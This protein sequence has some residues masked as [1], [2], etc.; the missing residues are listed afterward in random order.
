[1]AA[2]KNRQYTL[3]I[4]LNAL[5]HLGINLYSNIP[6]VISETVANSWDADAKVVSI[7][8]DK[9]KR[10]VTI[11]DDG[12][13]M[14]EDELNNRYL[15]VG[16]SKRDVEGTSTPIHGRHVMG[17]KGIGK[18][19]L[20]SIARTIEVHTVR[21]DNAGHILQR[22]ALRMNSD[23]IKKM[24]NKQAQGKQASYK[25]KALSQTLANMSRGTR[26]IISDLKSEGALQVEWIRK[27]LARRFSII[28]EEFDFQVKLDEKPIT[29]E[30]RD[31]FRSLQYIW[32]IGAD[33]GRFADAAINAKKKDYLDG[34]VDGALNYSV[35]G[36]IGTFDEQRNIDDKENNSIVV[37]AWGKLVQEDILQ[38]VDEAGLFMKYLIGEIRADFVDLDAEEDIATSDRQRLQK[39]E[40]RYK[41]LL[42]YVETIVKKTIKLKWAEWRK[43]NAKERALKNDVVREWY[44]Q[45]PVDNKKYA[46]EVFE[47]IETLEVP[48]ESLRKEL[49]KQSIL[50]FEAFAHRKNLSELQKIRTGEEFQRL[51]SIFNS[52]DNLEEA[53]FYTIAKSR[54]EALAKLEN[55]TAKTKERTIQELLFDHLWLLDT[56]WERPT[57]DQKMEAL[58]GKEWAKIDAKLTSDEKKGR[59]DIF[60]KTVAGKHIIIELKAYGVKPKISKL[61]DQVQK[62]DGA[63]RKIAKLCDPL[64][65]PLV[66]TICI[67]GHPPQ[68]SD[69][70]K[71]NRD[72][73]RAV[74]ARYV[75]YDELI[76]QTR[77]SY[78]D[79]LLAHE[80]IGRIRELVTRLGD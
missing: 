72:L 42:E 54:L 63:V 44:E 53:Y 34:V 52:M 46:H 59:I 9:N 80:K 21:V 30:D 14:N 28:G 50:A 1:M 3:T 35:S 66:E 17:R 62:Y 29:I 38:D 73:L 18:L 74:D 6:A 15:R 47:K 24:I 25:P 33:S 43:T 7:T 68:P 2:S 22:N 51:I 16:Y 78:R 40:P 12:R 77:E 32:Y 56:S 79:Y 37:L 69:K 60:Y 39:D 70:D 20:F 48:N 11:T 65:E 61:I 5:N 13:G 57:T 23:D 67:L 26:I 58:I 75:L 55:I 10:T 36:W 8:V 19:S 76:Q 41:A 49:Y 4:D 64:R 31:Y 45:L 27:R 71:Q